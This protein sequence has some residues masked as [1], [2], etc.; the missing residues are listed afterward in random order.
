M[1]LISDSNTLSI[2]L[3]ITILILALFLR[4]Y[5]L[6]QIP[7][8]ISWDEAA[9]GYNGY[10]IANWGRDEW[11]NFFP[12]VFKSFEDDKH[13]VHIYLTAVF[14]KII[15]LNEFSTRFPSAVFGTLNVLLIFILGRSLF[16]SL[17]VGITASFM[18]AISPYSLQFSRFNHELQFTLFFFM[19]GLVFFIKGLERKQFFLPMS[20]LSFGIALITYHSAKILVPAIL[21]LLIILYHREIRQV[22]RYFIY[23]LLSFLIFI[24]VIVFNPALLGLAR[25]KQTGFGSQDIERTKI[26]QTTK[27]E[28]F[29]KFE[30]YYAQYLLHFTPQYLFISGDNNARH[31]TQVVGQFFKIEAIFLILGLIGLIIKRNRQS[32]I[33]LAWAALAPIPSAVS[34][35]APHAARAM[36]MLGSFTLISAYGASLLLILLR[37]KYVKVTAIIVVLGIYGALF[38]DYS[39]Y[40]LTN[41]RIDKAI[42]WQYGMKQIVKYADKN[43]QYFQVYMTDQRAQPYIFFLYYL[44]TP[45]FEFLE[46]AQYNDTQSKSYN[47]VSFF[48]RYYFG[49]GDPI[50]Y[51]PTQYILQ[52]LEPS[53]YSGLRHKDGFEVKEL[54]KYPDGNDAY[55]IIT[56]RE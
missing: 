41:Y 7:P 10:T 38:K 6:D 50:E 14:I 36:F 48:E 12:L 19:T 21:I 27:N 30:I 54:I 11:G 37:H 42:D 28:F 47:L 23:G 20:F 35:E 29:A 34:K 55:F 46:S 24:I 18:L 32:F 3:L 8:H 31:S 49:V 1:K 16:K 2:I 33:L 17:T 53:K 44:K 13:P 52:I 4:I 45:L 39:S 5:K 15:G 22:R 9:V 40:Y 25:I 56:A 26:Y 51:V 43:P